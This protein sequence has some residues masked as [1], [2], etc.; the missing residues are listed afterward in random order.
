M[1]IMCTINCATHHR[2][3]YYIDNANIK[4][5]TNVDSD[6]RH[7]TDGDDRFCSDP[8]SDENMA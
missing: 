7:Q 1:K 8:V 2:L 6:D 5:A 3:L 4:I